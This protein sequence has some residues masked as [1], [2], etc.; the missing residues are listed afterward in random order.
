MVDGLSSESRL[1]FLILHRNIDRRSKKR[2]F[3]ILLGPP[4]TSIRARVLSAVLQRAGYVPSCR[5]PASYILEGKEKGK[6]GKTNKKGKLGFEGAGEGDT[7]DLEEKK[8]KDMERNYLVCS[9][10]RRRPDWAALPSAL[11]SSRGSRWRGTY[12]TSSLWGQNSFRHPPAASRLHADRQGGSYR[13]YTTTLP[14]QVA[15]W[16]ATS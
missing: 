8:E 9:S 5:R 6:K 3:C 14:T 1:D 12:V 15:K 2:A 4:I 7:K 11:T 16:L 13:A 10:L